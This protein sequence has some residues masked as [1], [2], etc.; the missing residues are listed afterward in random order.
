IGTCG[1]YQHV[2]VEFV[3]NVL[4]VADAEHAETSPQAERL[5]VT[6]L[7]CSVAGQLLPVL[8]IAGT[9]AAAIYRTPRP[10]EP[11]YCNYGMNPDYEQRIE[12]A[13]L[14]VSGRDEEGRARILELE[15]HPFYLVT[16]Y[17][18]QAREDHTE[19]HPFTRAFL[20]A[21]RAR[22]QERAR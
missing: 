7:V 14:R 13:G 20:D 6:P 8:P 11:Y 15:G 9:R 10:I 17:V 4:G 16:L 22:H 21:A 2:V 3:R 12:A 18:F 1:G 5:A 19:P